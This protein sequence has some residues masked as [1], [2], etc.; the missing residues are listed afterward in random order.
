MTTDNVDMV[1]IPEVP[2]INSDLNA[3]SELKVEV[4]K[5][6]NDINAIGKLSLAVGEFDPFA[7]PIDKADYESRK[8][9]YKSRHA[10][11]TQRST[12]SDHLRVK[13]PSY[14]HGEWVRNK[15]FEIHEA[16]TKGFVIDTEYASYN[17][18][19]GKKDGSPT[20][21]D[22]VVFMITPMANKE[23]LKELE[24]EEVRRRMG[25][26]D[27][28]SLT[29]KD[30]DRDGMLNKNTGGVPEGLSL[31]EEVEDVTNVDRIKGRELISRLKN[32]ET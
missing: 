28:K 9:A 1:E 7:A 25:N 13:V 11:V 6:P 16:Q 14:I 8:A 19:H 21:V 22:D 20:I 15:P 30:L 17:N 4:T 10:S 12:Y 24:L 5:S 27:K 3:K 23:A 31:I 2:T 26:F 18:I 32:Q 29:A